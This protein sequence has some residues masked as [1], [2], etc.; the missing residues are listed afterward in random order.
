MAE[1]PKPIP[2]EAEETRVDEFALSTFRRMGYQGR[3]PD[4]LV[5]C[6]N[7]F[8]RRKDTLYPGRLTPEGFASVSML[9]GLAESVN[10]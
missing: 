3:L 10:G 5:T 2:T 4:S 9:A 8:K 7:E 6:Y 1:K